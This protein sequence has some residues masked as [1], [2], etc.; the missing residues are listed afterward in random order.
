[1]CSTRNLEL[2]RS[3]GADEVI[4]YTADD[5]TQ[6]AERYDLIVDCVGN[7]SVNA[8][9]RALTRKGAL[10]TVGGDGL[11]G[12]FAALF[13]DFVVPQRLVS[14]I[15]KIGP[16]DLRTLAEL[17][18]EGKLTVPVDRTYP[19]AETADAIR[20]LETKHARGKVVVTV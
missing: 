18:K 20:Y 15:A 3:L 2:V 9:R 1:V 11:G 6:G 4:D 17:A 13:L 19:L 7:H 14:F 12:V 10:V 5:F 8:T 16:D